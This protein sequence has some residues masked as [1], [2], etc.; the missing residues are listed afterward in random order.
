MSSTLF[1]E[2]VLKHCEKNTYL[3]KIGINMIDHA[4]MLDWKFSAQY[5]DYVDSH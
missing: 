3:K 2:T 5:L 4:L 1:L